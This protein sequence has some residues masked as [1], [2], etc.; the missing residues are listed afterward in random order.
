MSI[1]YYLIHCDEHEERMPHITKL[2]EDFNQEIT[3]FKGINTTHVPTSE[4]VNYIQQINP[5]ITFSHFRYWQSGQIGCYLSHIGVMEHIIKNKESDYSVIFED[6]V[7]FDTTT[8]HSE[9]EKILQHNLEFDILFLGTSSNNK[10]EHIVDNIFH[11]NKIAHCW[12]TYAM[13]INNKHIEKIYNENCKII[14][15]IDVQLSF[16][17]R[18]NKIINLVIQPVLCTHSSNFQSMVEI[19]KLK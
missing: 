16:L 15:A 13:L 1:R 7:V 2:K 9:I 5:N 6:D 14:H 3:V 4:Q 19:I 10:G 11:V 17:N 18:C 12:G 8:L